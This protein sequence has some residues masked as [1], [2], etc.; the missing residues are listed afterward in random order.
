LR[1]VLPFGKFYGEIRKQ[2]STSTF[3]IAEV[4]DSVNREIPF[5]THENAHFL[6]ILKGEYEANLKDK[7]R[8]CSSSTILYYPAGTTHRD[9]F[10]N[11]GERRFMTVSLTCDANKELLE[12]IKLTDYSKDFNDFEVS[13]AGKRIR[14]ELQTPDNLSPFVLEGIA[15]ELLV[16]ATRSLDKSNQPPTWLKTARELLNDRC[17][18]DIKMADIA[19]EVRVHQLHLARTFRRFFGCSPGEYLRQRRIESASNLL[20]KSKK[21]I[22]EIALISGFA[23]QSNFTRS[24]KQNTGVTPA[25]FRRMYNP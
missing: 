5:H 3:V 9:H 19:E 7:K 24:F 4:E 2:I 6:F 11:A 18:E 15:N 17:N 12:G 14:K 25:E 16:Y 22:V 1:Q 8:F 13:L 21:T 10:Y 20:L 23:D